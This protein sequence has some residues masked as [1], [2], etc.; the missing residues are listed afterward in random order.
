MPWP[1]R[2]RT[3]IGAS[4]KPGQPRH[5]GQA[6]AQ[7]LALVRLQWPLAL[8]LVELVED[9]RQAGLGDA[10]AAV[11]HLHQQLAAALRGS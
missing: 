9:A 11:P 6:Q 2:E 5:D 8:H 10:D 3:E 4:I 7:S 1:T